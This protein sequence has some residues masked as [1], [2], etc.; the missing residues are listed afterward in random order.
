MAAEFWHVLNRGV[1][2]RDIVMDDRD[3]A[4]FIHDLYVMND[5]NIVQHIYQPQRQGLLPYSRRQL[6]RIHA[7]CLMNNHYHLLLS[8]ISEGGISAFMQKFNMGYS[9]Y[10]NERYKRTGVLWQ[11]KHKKIRIE[12][13]AHFMYVPY[14]IHLNPLDYGMRSWREGRAL[15]VTAALKKL[16]AYRWSS[17]LD[18]LGAKNFP[19]VVDKSELSELFGKSARYERGLTDI[20][21]SRTLASRSTAIE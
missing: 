18:Y 17:H 2:K 14:Y 5:A 7:F 8:P 6:V 20:I 13:D 15:D 12:R 10:F 1:E 21:T 9:K 3:R 19:S 11:G 16:R 4:R